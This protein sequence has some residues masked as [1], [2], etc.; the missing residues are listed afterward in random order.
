MEEWTKVGIEGFDE[1]FDKGIPRGVST[2]VAGGPGTGKTIFC[3]QTLNHAALNG[4]KCLYMSF[5]ES[6]ERL[7]KHMHDFGWNPEELEEK[8]LLRIER[9]EPLEVT[10]I[11]EALL[12]KTKGELLIDATPVLLPEGFK[13]DRVVVDSLSSIAASFVGREE[14]YRVYAEQLFRHLEDLN[15][16]SFLITESEADPARLTR[17]GIEEFL[18]DGVIVIYNLR[19]GDMRESAIEVLKMR[20]AKFQKKVVLMEIVDGSGMAVYPNQKVFGEF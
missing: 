20:G 15:V 10:R 6:P 14:N 13:P 17:S 18:A 1:L 19:K 7:R 16:T 11:V 5:E 2:L 4:E 8:G 12:E 3:L 9:Y